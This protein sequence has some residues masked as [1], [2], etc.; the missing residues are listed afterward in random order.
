MAAMFAFKTNDGYYGITFS[1]IGLIC[2]SAC[3]QAIF[4]LE[5]M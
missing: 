2:I 4:I 1:T 5:E 3:I